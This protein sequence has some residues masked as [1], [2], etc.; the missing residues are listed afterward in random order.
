MTDFAYQ[1]MFPLGKDET[2]YRQLT[3]RFVSTG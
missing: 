2:P 1:T 3:D